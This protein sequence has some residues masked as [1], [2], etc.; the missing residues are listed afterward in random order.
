MSNKSQT[1]QSY[2]KCLYKLHYIK[3]RHIWNV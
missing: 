1:V 2:K 3:A